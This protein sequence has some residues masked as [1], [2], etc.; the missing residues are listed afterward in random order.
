MISRLVVW[1]STHALLVF[2][3]LALAGGVS[4]AY[5]I[6]HFSVDVQAAALIPADAP[7]RREEARLESAFPQQRDEILVVIDGA[8]PEL[9]AMAAARLH[10]ALAARRDL[11]DLVERPGAG[12][13]F[14]EEGVLFFKTEEVQSTISGLIAAQPL[15]GPLAADPSLRGVMTSLTNASEGLV[16]GNSSATTFGRAAGALGRTAAG[17]LRGDTAYLPWG[18]L[19]GGGARSPDDLRQILL[20]APHPADGEMQPG[21]AATR[22]V[23][24]T[25]RLLSLDPAHGV[26]VRLTGEIPMELDELSTLGESTG[27]IALAGLGVVLLVIYLAVRSWRSVLAALLTVAVGLSITAAAGL[28]AFG[29]FN[30]LSVAFFPLFVGL[31]VDFAIQFCVRERAE[32]H[33]EPRPILALERTAAGVGQGLALAAGAMALGFFA[34]LPTR[35]RGLSELGAIAGF[36]MMVALLLSAT[37]LPALLSLLRPRYSRLDNGAAWLRHADQRIASHRRQILWIAAVVT[38]ASTALCLRLQINFD[39][40]RLR[41]PATESVST[42]REL[43]RDPGFGAEALDM[44]APDLNAARALAGRLHRL[45]EVGE[46]LS[47]DSLIPPDQAPKLAL[48]R[49]AAEL[50]DPTINPF[51]MASPPSDADEVQ[52]M[53]TAAEAVRRLAAARPDLEHA[54]LGRLADQLDQMA[55]GPKPVRARFAAAVTAGLPTMLAQVRALLSAHPVTLATTPQA[56]RGDWLA[57][58]GTARVQVTPAAAYAKLGGL[59]AYRIAVTRVAPA[60]VGPAVARVEVQQLILGAFALAA[61]LALATIAILLLLA[62][63]RLSDA[64]LS[65]TPVLLSMVLTGATCVLLRQDINLENLLAAPLLIGLGVSF[66]IYFVVAFRDGRTGL[67]ASSLTRAILCSAGT[68]GAAFGVL[69]LSRHPGTASLGVLLLI[70]LFWLVLAT[71]V[72]LPALLGVRAGSIASARASAGG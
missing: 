12:P 4:A 30:L 31:G 10:A 62:L 1:A 44:T 15:L 19:L 69:A 43:A 16:S 60:A 18:T 42:Y 14:E 5:V 9:A 33:G 32:A 8:T 47:A 51:D 26:R 72:V 35:Y 66:S 46:V 53:R 20:L 37:L 11:F 65:L 17:A 64:V 58:D 27:P 40:L 21:A 38:I 50:L 52:A 13:Y 2:A 56:V 28:A 54:A 25:A 70:A 57:A 63:R 71:L 3:V 68:T 29:R 34:F 48:I 49:D 41:S 61:A 39:P 55:N 6:E 24:S 22:L 67:L 45:P 7:W 23:R 59:S 36:G